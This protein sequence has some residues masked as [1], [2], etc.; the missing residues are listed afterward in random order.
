MDTVCMLR[1][2][3]WGYSYQLGTSNK[4]KLL[5]FQYLDYNFQLNIECKKS[6]P[7]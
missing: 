5:S 6:F 7:C 2:L 1:I 4:K 3:Y